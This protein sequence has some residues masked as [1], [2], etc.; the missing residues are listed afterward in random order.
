MIMANL[1]SLRNDKDVGFGFHGP[2]R[3]MS[4]M[5][6]Q[7]DRMF[8][9]FFSDPFRMNL[10]DFPQEMFQ[11]PFDLQET[12]DHFLVSI[13]LPGLSKDDV[14]V[15][16]SGNQLR[17]FGERKEESGKG[18]NR[19]RRFGSFEQTLTLPEGCKAEDIE[20]KFENGVLN[21]AIPKGE[22]MKPRQ[23]Q[24]GEGKSGAFAKQAGKAEGGKPENYE[25][26]A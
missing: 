17:V 22:E 9:D 5:Q 8:E 7:I 4:R 11:P 13:D 3:A 15:E 26:A 1:P 6:R 25:Q 12:D 23:I 24:I 21:I 14:K 2:M 20:A 16:A 10:P 18:K 19:Q